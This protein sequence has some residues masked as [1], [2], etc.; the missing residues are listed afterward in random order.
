M[1]ELRKRK[2]IAVWLLV[3]VFMIVIQIAL[4]GLTRLT[5]SGLSMTE[6]E[7]LMGF[8]PPLNDQDWQ[9]AFEGY[10]QI[11]QYKYV[12]SHF[13]LSDF[14]FI[15]FWEWFHRNW[16]R[17]IAVVFL[18]PFVYFLIKKYF[19]KD[20]IMPMALLFLIGGLQGFIGWYMVKSG[21]DESSLFYVSHIRLSVHL[22]T[23]L[24][25]LAYTL[26]FALKL[27]VPK[28]KLMHH[29]PTRNYFL[30]LIAVLTLQIFY[31]AFMAG[32]HAAKIAPS[33]P[34]MNGHWFPPKLMEYS[35]LND[36]IGVQFVHR[37]LAY[38]LYVMVIIGFV[39]AWKV[40]KENQCSILK[41]ASVWS[42]ILIN[43][44]VLLGI[45]TLLAVP[46]IVKDKFGLFETLAQFHQIGAM[47]L[48]IALMVVVF[49]LRGNL[50]ESK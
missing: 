33:W 49:M 26:W 48:L 47:F 20:M 12:N 5:G 40:A 35:W 14:K 25:L 38:L 16:A 27:L 21:L 18:V 2:V 28:E 50:K 43:L 39:K 23:A 37:G 30:V 15:F 32:L 46:Y 22:V 7:P 36:A 34:K 17:F 45:F 29:A 10:Q 11:A 1:E 9:K 3:G 31:G 4:G 44:Q 13:T 24:G 6:W 41:K 19:T 42:L 8:L